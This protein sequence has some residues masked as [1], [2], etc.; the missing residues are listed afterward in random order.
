MSFRSRLRLFFA[1]I[2]LVPMIALGVVLF[3]LA[4]SV[5]GA[6]GAALLLTVSVTDAAG[7]VRRVKRLTQRD[8]RSGAA[9]TALSGL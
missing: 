6:G 2:V 3:A 4:A 5:T 1:L 8:G 9:R 7:F